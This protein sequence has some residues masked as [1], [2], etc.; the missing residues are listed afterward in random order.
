MNRALRSAFDHMGDFIP[1]TGKELW[2]IYLS[3][4]PSEF[5]LFVKVGISTAPIKRIWGHHISSPFPL[6]AYSWA[7]VGGRQHTGLLER[8]V[9]ARYV[10]FS[11]RGEWLL[12]DLD[13]ETVDAELRKEINRSSSSSGKATLDWK[14][15]TPEEANDYANLVV[16]EKM[17]QKREKKAEGYGERVRRLYK[18]S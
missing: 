16:R 17:K 6:E 10:K 9:L 4:F 7:W 12:I 18:R 15:G 8:G 13:I 11:T 14:R 1:T 5:G 2:A 3:Y